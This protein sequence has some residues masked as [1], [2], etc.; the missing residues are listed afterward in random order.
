MKALYCFCKNKL[1]CNHHREANSGSRSCAMT[2]F[3][4]F[5]WVSASTDLLYMI[6][7]SSSWW[8][9]VPGAGLTHFRTKLKCFGSFTLLIIT[10]SHQPKLL[11][12]IFYFKVEILT[13]NSCMTRTHTAIL[14]CQSCWWILLH[15][16]L[17]TVLLALLGSP[18]NTAM[19]RWTQTRAAC[20][21]KIP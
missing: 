14:S 11:S 6:K 10:C 13:F 2:Y 16:S 19:F 8:R 7:S 17:T 3:I 20:W 12:C 18:P 9:L 5:R 1:T 15:T 21:S 4:Y